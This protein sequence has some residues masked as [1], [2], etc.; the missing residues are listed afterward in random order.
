MVLTWT[1]SDSESHIDDSEIDGTRVIG[2]RSSVVTAAYSASPWNISISSYLLPKIL[3]AISDFGP[4]LIETSD[5]LA[6]M[7]SYLAHR[8][9]GL[10]KLAERVPVVTFNHGLIGEVYRANADLPNPWQRQDIAAER[11]SL[12]WSDACFVPSQVAMR[13]L[14]RQVGNLS[15]TSLV[16]EPYCWSVNPVQTG[17][18]SNR[19][20]HA[21]R[22]S[23]SKGIDH[24][25]HFLN[26]VHSFTAIEQVLLIGHIEKT[27]FKISDGRD[28][29]LRRLNP[30]IAG[31]VE[32]SGQVP[33]ADIPELIAPG[34]VPGLSMNFSEQETF[35]YVFLEHLERGMRPFTIDRSAMAEFYPDHL[36]DLL[37]PHDFDLTILPNVHKRFI[38]DGASIVEEIREHA[39][40]Q[41]APSTFAARYEELSEQ[42]L[43]PNKSSVGIHSR[44]KT[45][46][47]S[48]VTVLMATY[49]P[50]KYIRDSVGS[51]LRQTV[52][53]REILIIDDG[54]DAP[55]SLALL[56]E[57][58]ARPLVRVVKSTAN[59]GLCSTRRKLIRQAPT[60]LSIF[61][62]DDDKIEKNYIERTLFAFNANELGADAVITWRK[63]FGQSK[64]THIDFNLEDHEHY[65]SNELR[66][67]CLIRTEVLRAVNFV[68]SMRNGE[69][70]DWDFWIRFKH[71]G[72]KAVLVPEPLFRYRFYEGSMSW[73]W[74]SG[75]AAVTADLRAGRL[76]E[77][78]A[79]DQ[80][81]ADVFL[82]LFGLQHVSQPDP[83][84]HSFAKW[85]A[86]RGMYIHQAR[87][88]RPIV[89]GILAMLFKASSSL[90]KRLV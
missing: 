74:S 29:V 58:A 35:N 26:V 30:Q 72:Y 59:E 82:E 60:P 87:R 12:R 14:A 70:D 56:A 15:T 52:L 45:Y 6:P 81:A 84:E 48:D 61:L 88:R 18:F 16:R 22:V 31:K 89:G 73:P 9:A 44:A 42:I 23:F 27:Q 46:E 90:A 38:S 65:L 2:V 19:Y 10:L 7:F 8:R 37:L 13:K 69:A 5:Y 11:T 1:Y 85:S 17:Q 32:F 40:A 55:A 34:G 47:G 53:P 36:R 3:Q 68:P 79:N 28:Y 76:S 75:Q 4:D 24:V 67:T 66:M 57:M 50:K 63:D 43:K 41:T 77:A 78:V 51:V 20:V 86:E 49:N 33:P 80:V 71:A 62:D 83:R 25:V 21:G 54:S 39:M 64:E